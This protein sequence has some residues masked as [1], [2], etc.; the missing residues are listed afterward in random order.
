MQITASKHP[1]HFSWGTLSL[2]NICTRARACARACARA[3]AR[4]RVQFHACDRAHVYV[5]SKVH[6]AKKDR[7]AQERRHWEIDR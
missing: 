7:D 2:C 3:H 4:G 5:Y 6:W 1:S